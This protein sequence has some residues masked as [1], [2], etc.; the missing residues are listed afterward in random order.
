VCGLDCD[1]ARLVCA[2]TGGGDGGCCRVLMAA[3]C[4]RS[5]SP[6]PRVLLSQPKQVPN[7]KTAFPHSAVARRVFMH[8]QEGGVGAEARQEG[9][10]ARKAGLRPAGEI[11]SGGC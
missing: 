10:R 4:S 8:R 11:A 1:S 3:G 9:E 6:P 2:T 7:R 5:S